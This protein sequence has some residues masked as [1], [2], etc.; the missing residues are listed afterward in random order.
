[1]KKLNLLKTVAILLFGAVLSATAQENSFKE[2]DLH[3]L[4]KD[5]WQQ[6]ASKTYRSTTASVVFN[7]ST[8]T[9]PT[10][11]EKFVR[12]VIPPERERIF[13][14]IETLEGVKRK[15]I[16]RI[17]A[18]QFIKENDGDW[19]EISGIGIGSGSGNGSGGSVKTERSVKRTLKKGVSVNNQIVDLYETVTTTFYP[20]NNR[21]DIWRE[22][23]WFNLSGLFVKTEIEY[24]NSESK[25]HSRTTR[26]Y[27]YNQKDIKIEA[28]IIKSKPKQTPK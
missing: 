24:Q 26:E 9:I 3:P 8:N 11:T 2:E 19:K 21:T 1:M 22:S 23:Y 17:G 5:A 12:E 7:N 10:R 13:S 27:E 6:L 4:V 14:I 28:P 15:E 25:I 18:R 16:I 20:A